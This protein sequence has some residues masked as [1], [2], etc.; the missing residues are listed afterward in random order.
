MLK[1]EVFFAGSNCRKCDQEQESY[2]CSKQHLQATLK[3]LNMT[4]RDYFDILENVSTRYFYIAGIAFLIGYVLLRKSLLHK[5]I[6]QRFPEGK[7]YLREIGYSIITMLFFAFIP[8]FL[9]KNPAIEPYT[10]FYTRIEEHG[11]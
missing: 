2:F 4:W 9:I 11:W 10:T 7:H 8:L 6:Q 5:K 3:K 1:V